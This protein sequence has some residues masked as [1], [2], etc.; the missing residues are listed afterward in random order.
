MVV[1]D[2]TLKV[3]SSCCSVYDVLYDGV[4]IVELISKQR[5][6]LPELN[7]LYFLSPSE[8][9]VR[10]LIE[11]F[12]DEKKPQ[13]RSAYVYFASP[14][15]LSKSDSSKI[16]ATLADSPTLLPRIRCL[17]EFNLSFIAYEQRVFHFGMPNALLEL[18]PLP[19][20]Y[21]LQKV[22]DDLISLC[23]TI[24]QKPAIRYHKNQLPWCEQLATLVHKGLEA[25]ELPSD[26]PGTTLLILDRSVDLAPLFIHEYTYQALAYDV[27]DLPVCC[28]EPPK[29]S[30]RD[31]P[32]VMEDVYEYDVTNNMGLVER[33][34][35][36]LGE[37][38]E[39]WVRYRHQHVQ[40][41]NQSVQEEVQL[42]LKEN[43]TAKVQQNMATT[44]EDTLRAIRSLPQYQ[45][46]LSRYWTHVT[47]S[48]KCFDRLQELKIM[49]VG[50]VEQDLCCGVDKDGKEISASK[51]QAAVGSL[52]SDDTIRPDEKLRLLL[53]E[54]TQILGLD[55]ADRAK[56]SKPAH[57][58]ED[59]REKIRHF[60]QRAK[61]ARYDL[62]R[63]EPAVREIMEY[64]SELFVV[65]R[66]LPG[67]AAAVIGRSTEW[68]WESS[69]PEVVQ[70]NSS[71]VLDKSKK[72]LIVFILGGIV[73]SEMRCAYEVSKELNCEVF[74]GGTNILT[75]S[76]V[77]KQLKEHEPVN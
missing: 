54:F 40:E 5:Q 22:A 56:K 77:L 41:V 32:V 6:P 30:S 62:S 74:I 60:K 18:F 26:H 9:S 38:D 58:F 43:S 27:L 8:D 35:A 39:V 12:K 36:I 1:D 31:T 46:A 49:T 61:R 24:G 23:V 28:N 63:F 25:E 66:C 33:K 15:R 69:A 53:L 45:E 70:K 59:D 50:A 72:G 52:V 68:T 73:Q 71:P 64:H 44:S 10:A 7:A 16:M 13:Y 47:L 17:F 3:L 51:L 4:T 11:D 29:K 2:K 57:R 65:V 75:P 37:Q 20:P 14:I 48:E 34:K 19:S 76:Q 21:L 55:T 42:F 67:A